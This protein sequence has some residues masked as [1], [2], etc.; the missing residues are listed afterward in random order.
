[1]ERPR[2]LTPDEVTLALSQLAGWRAEGDRLRREYA[3]KD[4]VDAWTFMSAMALVIQQMDHHPDWSNVYGTVRVELW[5]HDAGG[6]STRDVE[7]AKR[8][9]VTAARLRF[10]AGPA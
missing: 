5:T 1:M 2:K 4:F 6:I 10:R 3:F 7:L 9:E 8:M